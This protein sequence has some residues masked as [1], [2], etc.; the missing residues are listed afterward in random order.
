MKPVTYEELESTGPKTSGEISL[1][2]LENNLGE[3]N[4]HRLLRLSDK[5]TKIVVAMQNDRILG[6][7]CV[8][9]VE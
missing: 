9:F 8:S 3:V 7:G 6:F 1:I 4:L 2:Y 5:G